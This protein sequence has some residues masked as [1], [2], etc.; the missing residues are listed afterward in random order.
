M[1]VSPGDA[2]TPGEP[3]APETP[4]AEDPAEGRGSAPALLEMEPVSESTLGRAGRFEIDFAGVLLNMPLPF[5][6]EASSSNTSKRLLD[7][8]VVRLRY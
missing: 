1:E 3:V 8:V 6:W 5:P 4:E 2:P 7:I